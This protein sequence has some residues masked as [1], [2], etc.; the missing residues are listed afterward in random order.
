[1]PPEYI[2]DGTISKKFDVFSLGVMIIKIMAG[3]NGIYHR[4]T[5]PPKQFIE[6]VRKIVLRIMTEICEYYVFYVLLRYI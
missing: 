3:N 6:L 2:V 5:M 1:M 4:S